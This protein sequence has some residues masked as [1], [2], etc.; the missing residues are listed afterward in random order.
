MMSELTKA[1]KQ[2]AALEAWAE[3]WDNVGRFHYHHYLLP[4]L[5]Q[6]RQALA[7]WICQGIDLDGEQCQA[8]GR[9]GRYE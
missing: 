6:T 1:D 3:W 7:C 8:C 5:T 4:P 2:R 9:T